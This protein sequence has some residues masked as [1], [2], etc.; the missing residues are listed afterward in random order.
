MIYIIGGA[1][2][3]IYITSYSSIILNNSNPAKEYKC[4]GGVARN[5]CENLVRLKEDVKFISIVG[6]DEDGHSILEHLK[7]LGADVSECSI[8]LNHS[9]SKYYALLDKNNDMYVAMVCMDIL[10]D[11]SYNKLSFLESIVQKN[12]IV[13]LDTNFKEEIIA[14][15]LTKV[16]GI[17]IVD[18]I[19]QS[20]IKKI[21]NY[22][23]YIDVLK[24]NIYELEELYGQKIDSKEK[25]LKACQFVHHQGIKHL[26]VTLNKDGA[27]YYGDKGQYYFKN[28]DVDVVNATG[29]GDAFSA[30]IVYA[31]NHHF[32][33]LDT[34]KFASKMACETLK[35]DSSV[36]CKIGGI[37]NEY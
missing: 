24:P 23:E 16:K 30:G 6:N 19:S 10:N 27:Y 14:E 13:V 21:K 9:T 33:I 36:N 7:Q 35:V 3:D 31:F 17:K 22:M 8:S 26:F 18:A 29:A 20:K 5:I 37:I 15:L 1:N 11:L 25:F 4:Y 34:L 32:T 2:V 28:D 12:D